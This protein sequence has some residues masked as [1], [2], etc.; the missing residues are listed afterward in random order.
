MR[1]VHTLGDA[2]LAEIT[3]LDLEPAIV[4]TPTAGPSEAELIEI[5]VRHLTPAI[6][7]IRELFAHQRNL[8]DQ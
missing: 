7:E 1:L 8:S 6:R 2:R 3:G 4:K 5:L